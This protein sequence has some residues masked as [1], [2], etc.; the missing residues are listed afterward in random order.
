VLT[1]REISK[2]TN[3]YGPRGEAAEPGEPPELG[4]NIHQGIVGRLLSEIVEL[5]AAHRSQLSA[6]SG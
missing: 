4:R 1:K 3:L 5:W 2:M 6:A